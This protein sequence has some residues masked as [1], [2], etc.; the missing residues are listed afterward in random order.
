LIEVDRAGLL[1]KPTQSVD[2][3]LLMNIGAP[4]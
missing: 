4:E 3:V 1:K 2:Y